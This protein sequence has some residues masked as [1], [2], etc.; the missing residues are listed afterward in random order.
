MHGLLL[1]IAMGLY[2][3]RGDNVRIRATPRQL[4]REGAA[5]WA[6]MGEGRVQKGVGKRL[7]RRFND[8]LR[9]TAF[10]RFRHVLHGQSPKGARAIYMLAK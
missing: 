7:V 8:V 1:Y 10:L 6:C 4:D 5:T 3:I 9:F 2:D